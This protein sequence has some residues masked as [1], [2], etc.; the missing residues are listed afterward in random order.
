MLNAKVQLIIIITS[1]LVSLFRAKP[2]TQTL[3][4]TFEPSEST[5]I[6]TLMH[7][8]RYLAHSKAQIDFY[9]HAKKGQALFLYFSV[10]DIHPT[11]VV[12]A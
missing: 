7:M 6:S 11:A 12:G 2:F 4:V 10:S 1:P 3:P 8:L 9:R 5:D